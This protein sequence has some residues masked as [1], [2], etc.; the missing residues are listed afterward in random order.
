M[1]KP[2]FSLFKPY[3]NL[4]MAISEKPDGSMKI[5]GDPA[6]D[7][8]PQENRARFLKK[9]KIKPDD[10]IKTN[11]VHNGAVRV[12][13]QHDKGISIGQTDGFVT[14]EK[15]VFLS[16]TVGDCLPIFFYDRK[17]KAVGLVHCGWR[18]LVKDIMA[19]TLKLFKD[20]FN[21]SRENI[22]V[23]IG[24]GISGECYEIGPEIYEKYKKA[25][26]SSFILKNGKF[27]WDLK[28]ACFEELIK[29]GLPPNNI[30]VSPE[31]TYSLSDKYFSYRRDKPKRLETMLVVFG[32]K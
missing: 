28:K 29:Q 32:R 22:L 12:V 13:R 14:R 18:E 2:L 6:N 7:R 17:E 30:E 11:S 1:S 19:S 3:K 4:V 31:C 8:R 5:F 9:I 27:F 16:I 10:L 15:K 21:S 25:Y 24:P 23:G 26:P 20:N